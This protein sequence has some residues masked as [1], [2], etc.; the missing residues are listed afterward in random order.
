MLISDYE[1]LGPQGELYGRY[2][3]HPTPAQIPL[4]A[5]VKEVQPGLT[6]GE[7]PSETAARKLL[8]G[9]PGA[10]LELA[11]STLQR[12]AIISIPLFLL[13]IPF[14]KAVA[15]SIL[16]ATLVTLSVVAYVRGGE[17]P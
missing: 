7:L 6:I 3:T 15:G 4:Y 10:F 14:W 17:K 16:S 1:V 5:M 11:S 13:K 9:E 2:K 12:A 8:A